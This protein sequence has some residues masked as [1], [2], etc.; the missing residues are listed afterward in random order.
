MKS[1]SRKY[2]YGECHVCGGQV[3]EKQVNQDFWVRGKLVVVE[4]VPAGVCAQCGEKVIAAEAGIEL[5][6]LLSKTNGLRKARRMAVPVLR[7]AKKIA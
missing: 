1:K 6:E 3:R 5:A 4:K 2:D 7:F